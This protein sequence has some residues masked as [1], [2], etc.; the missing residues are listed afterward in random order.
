[1]RPDNNVNGNWTSIRYM[2]PDSGNSENP[3]MRTGLTSWGVTRTMYNYAYDARPRQWY[4]GGKKLY[5]AKPSLPTG[6][7][8][9]HGVNVGWFPMYLWQTVIPEIGADAN[10]LT[11]LS[12][13]APM[14]HTALVLILTE[15]RDCFVLICSGRTRHSVVRAERGICWCG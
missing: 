14:L 4:R 6:A 3:A 5:D 2:G 9:F 10:A 11:P 1:M 15:K 13:Q 7:Q 12:E 8:A